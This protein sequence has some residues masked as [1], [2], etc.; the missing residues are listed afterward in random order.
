ME[1]A[2]SDGTASGWDTYSGKSD[3]GCAPPSV[4]RDHGLAPGC[5]VCMDLVPPILPTDLA[6]LEKGA[7]VS[8]SNMGLGAEGPAIQPIRRRQQGPIG[9]IDI[10]A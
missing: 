5:S 8:D 1:G 4:R 9:G 7:G 10:A 3:H 6:G 2:G